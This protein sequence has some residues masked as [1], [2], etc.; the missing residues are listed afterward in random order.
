MSLFTIA[1]IA[2]TIGVLILMAKTYHYA[3]FKGYGDSVAVAVAAKAMNKKQLQ[4]CVDWLE[5]QRK[6]SL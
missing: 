4:K 6:K 5:E 3:Y 2:N 1:L